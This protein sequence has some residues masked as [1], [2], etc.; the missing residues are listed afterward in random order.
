MLNFKKKKSCL[1]QC[2]NIPWVK[3]LST[4][5]QKVYLEPCQVSEMEGFEKH[6]I[7]DV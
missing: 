1:A 7:L 4:M 2:T 3:G 6:I 5:K